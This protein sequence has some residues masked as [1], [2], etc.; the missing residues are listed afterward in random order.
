MADMTKT[1]LLGG[2]NA[3]CW[4]ATAKQRCYS[5]LA[6]SSRAE[7]VIIGAGIVGLTTA[8]RLCEAGRSVILLEALRV[9]CQVTGRST[10]KITTQH[11]LIYDNLIRDMG[12]AAAQSYADANRAGVDQIL[13]W[14]IA[15]RIECDLEIKP[16]YAYT[17]DVAR[18][19]ELTAEA[20]AARQVGLDAEVVERAPLPFETAGALRFP[21]QAQFNPIQYSV[22]LARAVETLGGRVFEMSRVVSI[23]EGSRWRVS[24]D[25][26]VVDAENVVVATNMT[27]KSPVGMANRTQPRS[28]TAIAFRLDDPTPFD[29]FFLGIDEPTRSIRTARDDKG[30]LLLVLGPKFNTGQ[31]A[32]VAGRFVELEAWA[33][34]NLPVGDVAWRWCNEDYDTPDR[35]PYAGEPDPDKSPGFHIATGFNAWGISNGTAVGKLIAGR[36]LRQPCPWEELYDPARPYDK[37]FHVNGSSRSIVASFDEIGPGEGGV[38]VSGKQKIAAWRDGSGKLHAVSAVCTHKGCTV[39]WNNADRTWDCSCHGSIFAADGSLI[40]GPARK[41]LHPIDL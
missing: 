8:L 29:G 7:I 12:P 40:H 33:R 19:G 1:A 36:I 28:H 26:G 15:H 14:T 22:G 18:R 6:G 30:P 10:A 9:G 21:D 39:S 17:T 37:T 4:A 13:D 35:V 41:P 34:A 5:S 23:D 31:E 2:K 3:S 20:N 25:N 16:A 32:D 24:T 38:V 11:G 27:I